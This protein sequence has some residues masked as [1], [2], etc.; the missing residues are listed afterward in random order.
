MISEGRVGPV[1]QPDGLIAP[2]R[3]ARTGEMATINSHGLY[4][5]Q[6]SRGNCYALNLITGTGVAAGQI[7][8]G[9]A[10]AATQFAVFNPLGTNKNLVLLRF[11]MGII[12]GTAGAGAVIHS[13][14]STVPT[15]AASGTPVNL[16]AGA[17][18]ASVAQTYTSAAGAALTGGSAPT[19]LLVSTISYTNTAQATVTPAVIEDWLDGSIVI[20]PGKGWAPLQ[21]AAGTSMLVT[22]GVMWE[23]VSI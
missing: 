20:P 2:V 7:V 6:V 12:S 11:R 15:L 3:T 1:V 9:A 18:M 23:E 10:A 13:A 14:Y 22:Y 8:A 19:S 5:E 4:Q 17:P 16:L 21:P